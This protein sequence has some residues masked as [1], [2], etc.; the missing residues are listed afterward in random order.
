[1]GQTECKL[2]LGHEVALNSMQ[3][4]SPSGREYMHIHSLCQSG[5]EKRSNTVEAQGPTEIMALTRG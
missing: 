4:P 5:E 1:M 3:K 2:L